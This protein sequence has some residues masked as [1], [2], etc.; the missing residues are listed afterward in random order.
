MPPEYS[1]VW[2]LG[3]DVCLAGAP[4]DTWCPFGEK[5]KP[6]SGPL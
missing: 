2:D 3:G 1:L 6:L 5:G 4:G